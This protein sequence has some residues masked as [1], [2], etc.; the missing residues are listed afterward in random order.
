MRNVCS[1]RSLGKW[2]KRITKKKQSR[3][4]LNC[5]TVCVILSCAVFNL[6]VEGSQLPKQVGSRKMSRACSYI[7]TIKSEMILA[8]FHDVAGTNASNTIGSHG[9]LC[10]SAHTP[11]TVHRAVTAIRM[12]IEA[13]EPKRQLHASRNN[14]IRNRTDSEQASHRWR[15]STEYLIFYA[16]LI[17]Q[18]S[19]QCVLWVH[20]N[21]NNK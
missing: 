14:I 9:G 13:C 16:K 8:S 11:S 21:H 7:N 5:I 2:E 20:Q 15:I 19:R 12:D 17:K 6:G 3:I 10:T 4:Y 1:Q 18:K